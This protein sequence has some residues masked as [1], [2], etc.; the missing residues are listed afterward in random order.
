M[1]P[2]KAWRPNVNEIYFSVDVNGVI[3]E[4][5]VISMHDLMRVR[6]GNCFR[7]RKEAIAA[8]KRVRK[9]LRG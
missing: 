5:R 3:N 6:A 7:T 8:L 1:T 9:A 2:K 4:C